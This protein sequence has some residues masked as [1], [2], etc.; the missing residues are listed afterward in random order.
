MRFFEFLRNRETLA[1]IFRIVQ[2]VARASKTAIE[3][4]EALATRL[5]VGARAGDFDDAIKRL[6][7]NDELVRDFIKNG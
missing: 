7:D 3:A 2:Q 6:S 5:A 4:R 1:L